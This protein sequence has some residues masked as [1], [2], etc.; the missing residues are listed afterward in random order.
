M[1]MAKNKKMSEAYVT[2]ALLAMVGGYLDAYTY[3][4]RGHVFANA[5][6]GNIVL[7]GIKI[8]A[9]EWEQSLHYLAPVVSFFLGI[10]VA[11]MI[12]SKYRKNAKI[13]WRQVIIILEVFVLTLVAFIP[14]GN[15]DTL[16]NILI[17]FVCSLQVEGFRTMNGKVY[18][19]TMCTGNLRSATE[20]LYDYKQTRDRQS[21]QDS[22]QYYGIILFFILGALIGSF[23]TNIFAVKAVLFGSAGLTVVF[24]LMFI[25]Y[26]PKSR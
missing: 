16:A 13:Q 17:S 22:L 23:V 6:T 10:L 15:E 7:L 11:E 3:I 25:K 4:G 26:S 8:A 1:M 20:K 19:T 2:G 14:E 18:A 5:Q 9:G 21:L 12:K 24:F